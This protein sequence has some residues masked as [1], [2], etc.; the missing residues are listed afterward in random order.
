MC[1]S[2][3]TTRDVKHDVKHLQLHVENPPAWVKTADGSANASAGLVIALRV[4]LDNE[5]TLVKSVKLLYS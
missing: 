1:D 3:K 4:L 2:C 5:K